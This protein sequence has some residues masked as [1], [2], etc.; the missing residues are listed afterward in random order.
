[1]ADLIAKEL[2][3]F[4]Q[5]AEVGLILSFVGLNRFLMQ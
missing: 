5:P 1:M 2:E 4:S 3:T